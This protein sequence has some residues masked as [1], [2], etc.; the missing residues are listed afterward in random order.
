MTPPRTALIAGC[1]YLGTEVAR[2]FLAAG[3][4]VAGLTRRPE[5]ALAV[6]E[7]TGIWM[8]AA[9]LGD[10]RAVVRAL[11][12]LSSP[13]VVVHC[14]SSSR[15]GPE[16]YRNVF[17]EGTLNLFDALRPERFLFTS[18]T[19]VYAQTDGGEVDESSPAAPTTETGRILV[20][21][22]RL[23]VAAGGLVARL[24]GLYGPGR[25]VV[26][27]KFLD[28]TAVLE[29]GGSRWLNQ[30]HRDDAA[31]ALVHLATV[32]WRGGEIYNVA[33]DEPLSQRAAY[34]GLARHFQRPEPPEG[35]RPEGRKRGWTH[36]RVS[37][38]KLKATGWAPAYPNFLDAVREDKRLA[39]GAC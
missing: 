22:E 19:S 36:K 35:P 16:A 38:K 15:G 23:A 9:D 11:E 13:T 27:R 29:D 12:G 34:A 21:A 6:A 10:Q 31:S 3:W 14:A 17:V 2:R 37:N 8:A 30:I 39:A 1:G 26:L 28:N 7:E 20:E 33:D 18:S 4:K 32:A 25:S 5:Q 24:A